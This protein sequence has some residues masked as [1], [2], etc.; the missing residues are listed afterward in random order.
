MLKRIVLLPLLGLIMTAQTGPAAAQYMPAP[1]QPYQ[2][3]PQ[4]YYNQPQ[5][6]PN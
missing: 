2:Y 6:M 1:A 5:A 4:V 3:A